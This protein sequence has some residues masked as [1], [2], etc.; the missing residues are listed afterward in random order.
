MP[1]RDPTPGRRVLTLGAVAVVLLALAGATAVQPRLL[2]GAAGALGTALAPVEELSTSAGNGVAGVWQNL[3][4]LWSLRAQNAHDRAEIA[5]LQHKLLQYNEVLAQN[6]QLEGLLHL[7]QSAASG[8]AQGIPAVVIGRSPDSW[9]NYLTVDQ[10]SADGVQAGMVA[11]TTQGLVGRVEP[12]V[13]GHSARIMLLTDPSFDVG[14]VVQRSSSRQE[15]YAQGQLGGQALS[16]TFFSPTADVRSGDLLVTSGLGGN[17][18][19]GIAV[20][21]VSAVST[22]GSGLVRK[23]TV[24]PA[25][26]L[27]SLEDVLLLAPGGAAGG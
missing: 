21:T 1:M 16:A 25:A 26:S 27:Q 23:A 18:P 9:F 3:A 12:G 19:A 17:F 6:H 2:A 20:G 4:G 13:A 8:G 24:T 14:I 15:G 5:A 10:G 22:G 7:Q 11:V